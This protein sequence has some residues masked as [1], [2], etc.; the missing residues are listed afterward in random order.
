MAEKFCERFFYP[1]VP[2]SKCDNMIPASGRCTMGLTGCAYH[3][4]LNNEEYAI[5]NN[6]RIVKMQNAQI[7]A[8]LQKQK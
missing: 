5:L 2:Y 6:L 1:E 7:L 3:L 4:N 8:K